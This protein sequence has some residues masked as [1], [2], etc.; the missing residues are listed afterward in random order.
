MQTVSFDLSKLPD[1]QAFYQQFRETF[2]L[3]TFGNNLDALWDVLTGELA[4]PLRI[5]LYHVSHSPAEQTW[6]RIVA[7]M[8]E[9]EQETF[10]AFSLRIV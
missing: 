4:L 7:V 1:E 3:E 9:A 2:A 8:K 6:Q 5:T 10:G